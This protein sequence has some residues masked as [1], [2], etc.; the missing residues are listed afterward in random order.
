M[1]GKRFATRINSF[2][3]AWDQPGKPSLRQM[4]K[5]AA[6]VEGLAELDLNFP[7]T[8]PHARRARGSPTAA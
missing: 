4:V 6:K 1:F 2:T 3:S 5:R 8:P 7:I